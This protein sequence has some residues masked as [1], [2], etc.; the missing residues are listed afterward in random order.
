M[1][2]RIEQIQ[3][4]GEAAIAAASS[5]AALEELRIRLLGRK[6]ELPQLLRGV[7]ALD[8]EQRAVVGRAANIARGT[9]ERLITARDAELSA[10]ELD[11][12][13]L[14]DRVDVTLPGD[15]AEPPGR[16]HLLT[17]TRREIED[18]F[19]GLGY[20]IAEGP[21]VELVHYNFD[22]LNHSPTHPARDLS[23]TFYV[24]PAG[25]E[26]DP[27]DANTQLLRTHTS[28]MQVRAMELQPP[29]LYL[30]VPG[31][32]Y[33]PDSDATHTP[34]FHQVE[35]LAVDE[36]IT[37]ADLKGTL[38]T[39]ARATFGERREV[40]LR[41]HFFPFTE[42]SAEVDVSCFRCTGGKLADGSRCPLCGGSGWIE[43]LGAGMVDPNVF[44]HVREHGY[45]PERV[46]GFAFG[47]GVERI[48]FLKH[49]V[50]DLRLFFDNDL[51][52]LEQFG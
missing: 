41:P 20:S 3:R 4:E 45:D 37:M 24:Q 34:Q 31:R 29:P 48:A 26:L 8:A 43:V 46:Q 12:R 28:P 5:S 11:A 39:W 36:D 15:P 52:F 19:L 35:G 51:R 9:L 17:Q 13:L 27:L 23:D 22:A 2:E 16:L 42:P 10:T 40:R 38:E 50:P 7:A 44:A 14:G 6:A 21:E 1:I 30:I 32:V 47:M 49:G 18:I 25:G 33:R